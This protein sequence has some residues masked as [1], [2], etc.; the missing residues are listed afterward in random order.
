MTPRQY[1][2]WPEWQQVPRF[3][4]LGA[5]TEAQSSDSVMSKGFCLDAEF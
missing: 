1:D 2:D 4:T 3:R 5:P